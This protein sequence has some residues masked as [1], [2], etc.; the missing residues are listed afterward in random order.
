MTKTNQDIIGG[1]CVRD[2]AGELAFDVSLRK[3]HGKVII[4][5]FLI[6]SLNGIDRLRQNGA[7]ST[8]CTH[9]VRVLANRA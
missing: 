3:Q 2:D 5:N 8:S 7:R 4:T 6:Q 9:R 1:K